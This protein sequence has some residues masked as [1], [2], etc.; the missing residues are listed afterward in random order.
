MTEPSRVPSH[1][2]AGFRYEPSGSAFDETFTAAGEPRPHLREFWRGLEAL[3]A[4][5]ITKRW[6]QGGRMI[7]ENGVTY[8][9]YG[10]PRGM[11]RPWVLDPI[12]LVLAPDE[13][14]RVARGL[15]QRA[16]VLNAVLADVYGPQRLLVEGLLPPEIVFQSPNF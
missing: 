5:E 7:R 9:V 1:P 15:D 16:R 3:G 11:D 14:S 4:S 2:P 6:E 12:P 10:D 8:N 13:W